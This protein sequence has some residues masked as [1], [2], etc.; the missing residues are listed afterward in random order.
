MAEKKMKIEDVNRSIQVTKGN[1][2]QSGFITH[3]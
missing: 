1:V 2:E 3:E